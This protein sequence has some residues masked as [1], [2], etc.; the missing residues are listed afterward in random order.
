VLEEETVVSRLAKL[1]RDAEVDVLVG[2]PG[3]FSELTRLPTAKPMERPGVRFVSSGSALPRQVANAFH[4][5]YGVKVLSCYHSTEAGPVAIDRTGDEPLTVGTPF[6]DVELRVATADLRDLP[7]GTPGCIW[8]RSQAVAA[9]SVP[10]LPAALRRAGVPVG[11]LSSDGWF[12]SGDLGY[13]DKQGRLVMTGREDDL[14]KVEGRRV[15]L[16]EV[17]GCL[18]AFALVREAQVRVVMDDSG[19]PRVVARVV[20]SGRCRAEDLIDHC[21]KLLAPYKVPRQI[22]ICEELK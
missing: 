2:T 21:A 12:R 17:E 1:I 10:K 20:P 5:K 8:V 13:L 11:R 18:E 7:V 6:S 22:E 15:A 3:S 14:V 9:A 19:E 16:G 4:E